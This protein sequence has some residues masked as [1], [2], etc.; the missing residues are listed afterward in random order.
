MIRQGSTGTQHAG[1]LLAVGGTLGVF[2]LVLLAGKLAFDRVTPVESPEALARVLEW[3]PRMLIGV[4]GALA[5]TATVLVSVE[6]Y[7]RKG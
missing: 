7:E 1:V 3:G 5:A 4:G 6:W 2:G